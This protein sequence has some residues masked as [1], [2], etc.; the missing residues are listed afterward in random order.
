[1]IEHEQEKMQLVAQIVLHFTQEQT[2]EMYLLLRI[3]MGM[4]FMRDRMQADQ[5]MFLKLKMLHGE[6]KRKQ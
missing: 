3:Q 5:M 2:E 4:L 6:N 1:M